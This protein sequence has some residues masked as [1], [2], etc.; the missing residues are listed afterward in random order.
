MLWSKDKNFWRYNDPVGVEKKPSINFFFISIYNNTYYERGFDMSKHIKDVGKFYFNMKELC[1]EH[2]SNIPI[3]FER[4][5]KRY[6]EFYLYAKNR[7]RAYSYLYVGVEMK[8][9]YPVGDGYQN[10]PK[11]DWLAGDTFPEDKYK[12]LK[13]HTVSDFYKT[14]ENR[15]ELELISDMLM[16]AGGDLFKHQFDYIIEKDKDGNPTAVVIRLLSYTR[17]KYDVFISHGQVLDATRNI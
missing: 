15:K 10:D 16:C 9:I 2:D 5:G 1:Y 12:I 7:N 17:N 11:Y 13:K 14:I 8:D 3:Y 6:E 4:D